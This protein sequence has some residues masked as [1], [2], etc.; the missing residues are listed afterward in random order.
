ME[1]QCRP[2]SRLWLAVT[3]PGWVSIYRHPNAGRHPTPG[4][5]QGRRTCLHAEGTFPF[6]V[7]RGPWPSPDS[8]RPARPAPLRS[9]P[10]RRRSSPAS[11]A[12]CPRPAAP[13]WLRPRPRPRPRRAYLQQQFDPLDGGDRGLGH[14]SGD[15]AGQEILQ[16]AQRLIAHGDSRAHTAS[17]SPALALA[18]ARPGTATGSPSPRD[19]KG[20]LAS[21]RSPPYMPRAASRERRRDPGARR[22]PRIG[23]AG[24]WTPPR[25]P[26][27][28]Q[29]ATG[30]KALPGGRGG[31][32][33]VP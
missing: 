4:I 28:R 31:P 20:P 32:G 33:A 22:A 5:C 16:E 29:R 10:P 6:A 27:P 13:G 15:A 2:R 12:P 8:P 11:R 24:A 26:P 7:G 14:G 3:Y 18:S 23:W 1:G 25:R 9:A 19:A 17:G 21:P 30:A